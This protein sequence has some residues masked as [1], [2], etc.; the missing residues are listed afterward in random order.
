MVPV[1]KIRAN[2]VSYKHFKQTTTFS[3]QIETL[4]NSF[5]PGNSNKLAISIRPISVYVVNRKGFRTLL[6]FVK[7]TISNKTR[8]DKKLK[9]GNV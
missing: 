1:R 7:Y 3:C 6:V 5:A 9:A 8:E 4:L 2:R